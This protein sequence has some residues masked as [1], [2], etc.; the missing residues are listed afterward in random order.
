MSRKKDLIAKAEELGVDVD[1]SWSIKVIEEAIEEAEAMPT[2]EM[3]ETASE[4]DTP[5]PTPSPD[6]LPSDSTGDPES[7]HDPSPSDTPPDLP[8]V[9]AH[10]P[11]TAAPPAAPAAPAPVPSGPAPTIKTA[12]AIP[13]GVH[14]VR[15]MFRERLQFVYAG[16]RYDV[17]KN[18]VA[19]IPE[20][21][22]QA[23]AR[24]RPAS[25]VWY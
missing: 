10:E 14:K 11:P 17:H 20:E 8:I 2:E 16:V 7:T 6:E 25:I 24:A 5:A 12:E 1:P 3:P 23:I 4:S 21:H 19:E 15:V 22:A 9:N 18:E 13:A